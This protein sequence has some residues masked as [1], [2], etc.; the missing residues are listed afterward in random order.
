[1]TVSVFDRKKEDYNFE[2]SEGATGMAL[3]V[4]LFFAFNTVVARWL[5]QFFPV[6]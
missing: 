6:F 4:A 2:R 3:Q 5:E 1:M